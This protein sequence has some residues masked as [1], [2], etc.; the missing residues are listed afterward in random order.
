[1]IIKVCGLRDAENIRRVEMLEVDWLG[2][3]FYGRSVRFVSSE[4]KYREAIMHCKKRKVGVF[5]N[6][7][8]ETI[9][10][11]AKLFRLQILQLHGDETFDLCHELRQRGFSVIKAFS[12]ATS[13]D[14]HQ[15]ENF[16]NGCDYFLF[17]TKNSGY[18][19][20]GKRFDWALLD[21]YQGKTP[22]LL[23]G[24]LTPDCVEDIK[25]LKHPQFAGIDLNSGFEISPAIKDICKLKDFI[26]KI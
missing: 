25:R 5:V 13:T 23:S 19:G 7:S 15:T 20:S 16:R 6:E 14:F 2:F 11:K 8:L 3:I 1:M 4:S 24:G 18:G 26:K 10:E 22:F 9:L 17:D 21:N 12:I